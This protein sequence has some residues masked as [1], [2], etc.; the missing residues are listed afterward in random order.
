MKPKCKV[1]VGMQRKAPSLWAPHNKAVNP[2]HPRDH[3]P[4]WGPWAQL[5]LG[6]AVRRVMASTTTCRQRNYSPSVGTGGAQSF[7]LDSFPSWSSIPPSQNWSQNL[8]VLHW[9]DCDQL[10][11]MGIGSSASPLLKRKPLPPGAHNLLQ[12][13]LA[14]KC[15]RI[16]SSPHWW[17]LKKF[18]VFSLGF[19]VL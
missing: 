6:I 2:S 14:Q 19:R 15:V 4:C 7:G 11:V 13:S 9:E 16:L 3:S 10:R 8:T 12:H 1:D 17:L 18:A 5:V